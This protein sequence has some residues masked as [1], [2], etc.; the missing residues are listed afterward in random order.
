M[1]GEESVRQSLL[2]VVNIL[3]ENYSNQPRGIGRHRANR[4][5]IRLRAR[6]QISPE[7]KKAMES[8]I[9]HIQTHGF[10]NAFGEQRF[11]R[12]NIERAMDFFRL[13]HIPDPTQHYHLKLKLQAFPSLYFNQLAVRRYESGDFLVD[14]D[15]LVH[16]D[17]QGSRQYGVYD[18]TK[19]VVRPFD[20]AQLKDRYENQ[21]SFVPENFFDTIDYATERISTGLMMGGRILLAPEE[22]RARAYEDQLLG[23]AQFFPLREQL[24]RAYHLRGHRRPLFVIS[25]DLTYHRE[26]DDLIISFTLPVGS[27]ATVLLGRLFDSIDP[28][29]VQQCGWGI[30]IM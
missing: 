18:D 22:T 5:T 27:Y 25:E 29:T 23:E 8:Q 9:H 26:E 12:R 21:S 11:G 10:P 20:Y 7:L 28:E 4:F 1:G 30:E 2:E 15:I 13:D 16:Q 14:G 19:K 6:E 24:A 17:E 3:D